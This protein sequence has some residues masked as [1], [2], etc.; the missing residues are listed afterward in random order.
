MLS[1]P[2]ETDHVKLNAADQSQLS[3]SQEPEALLDIEEIQFKKIKKIFDDLNLKQ[4][5]EFISKFVKT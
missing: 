2:V 3:F 4:K 5:K 1:I